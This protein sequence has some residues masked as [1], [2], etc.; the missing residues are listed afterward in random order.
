MEIRKGAIAA[1]KMIDECGFDN[2]FEIPLE[3]LVAGRG[4]ILRY[5]E[6][7]G[8]DGRIVFGKLGKAI[9]TINSKIEYE[10]KRRFTIAHEL[11]HFEMHKNIAPHNDS[12]ITMSS[13]KNG[14][15]ETEANQFA[16]ELLLPKGIFC[17]E[18]NHKKFSPSLLRSLAETFNS[19][20]TSVVFRYLEIGN[21]PIF[22]FYSQNN[23]LKYWKHTDNYYLKVKDITNLKLPDDSVASEFYREGKIYS[24]EESAQQISKSTWFELG[25]YDTDETF[26]EYCIITPKYNTVLSVVWQ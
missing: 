24:K 20:L 12:E 17:Q 15:Q 21:H 25:K 4:A 11:G 6:L 23:I 18:L 13:F 7:K 10:G 3:K 22:I 8:A 5:S 1:N 9:I 19:S 26:F 2:I 14:N 16:A